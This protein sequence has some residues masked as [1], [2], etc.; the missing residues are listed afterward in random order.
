MDEKIGKN[1]HWL[2][3]IPPQLNKNIQLSITPQQ[4]QKNILVL[5]I[6]TH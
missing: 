1:N 3:T 5:M 6:T 2:Q 4:S